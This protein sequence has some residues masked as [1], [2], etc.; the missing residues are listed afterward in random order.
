MQS[1]LYEKVKSHVLCEIC[2]EFGADLLLN[3]CGHS[4]CSTCCLR[5]LG[6]DSKMKCCF[7]R[8]LCD[9]IVPNR[10]I[11]LLCQEI[12]IE[13][14]DM[15]HKV[16]AT[17]IWNRHMHIDKQENASG[18]LYMADIQHRTEE[19]ERGEVQFAADWGEIDIMATIERQWETTADE[20]DED[21]I[22]LQNI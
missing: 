19:E 20:D 7:C 15:F 9:N 5:V 3:P 18:P 17:Q 11:V 21:V 16:Q 10:V 14:N 2:F 8:N 12:N 6:D 22:F 1:A 4:I 13:V